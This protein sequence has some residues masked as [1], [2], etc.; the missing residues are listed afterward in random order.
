MPLPEQQAGLAQRA[1]R[2]GDR[3]ARRCARALAGWLPTCGEPPSP[4]MPHPVL[5]D[6]SQEEMTPLQSCNGR[7]PVGQQQATSFNRLARLPCSQPSP[8]SAGGGWLLHRASSATL[9]FCGSVGTCTPRHLAGPAQGHSRQL[10]FG[11][12]KL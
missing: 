8:Q 4:P 11:G 10:M 7:S 6:T 5:L 9:G 3:S 1:G 12:G 2:G